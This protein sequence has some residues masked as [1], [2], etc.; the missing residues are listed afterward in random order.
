MLENV[1]RLRLALTVVGTSPRPPHGRPKLG[2]LTVAARGSSS[3]RKGH[4]CQHE[5]QQLETSSRSVFAPQSGRKSHQTAV[6]EATERQTFRAKKV[7]CCGTDPS[8]AG[9]A[10]V[11]RASGFHVELVNG[12]FN[13][14]RSSTRMTQLLSD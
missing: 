14:P 2:E 13:L 12:I 7:G 10:K 5:R 11:P 3:L 6:S 4:E 9:R 1:P 8:E